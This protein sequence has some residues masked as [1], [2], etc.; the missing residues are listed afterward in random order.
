MRWRTSPPVYHPLGFIEPCL[1]TNGGTV[2]TGVQWAFEIKH[3]GF[4]LIC[5][6]DGDRVRVFSRNGRDWTDRVPLI[7]EAI[8]KLRVKSVTLDGEGVV[9]RPDGVTDF[10]RLRAAVGRLGSRDAFL[11][12]FDLLELDGEN[13]RLYEWHVRRTTL[14]S[15]IKRAGAGIRLSEHLDG[16]GAAAFQHACRMGLEG[17]VAKRRD[18]PYRSGR[19]PDW[20]KVKNPHAPAAS[21]T[22][23]W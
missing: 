5:R 11:Y 4:R 7:A 20:I 23:E 19:S 2:P 9:C 18:R 16:D 1:P 17:I 3:D 8:G 21:R 6:R 12:A 13:M 15:L 14:R 22:M 10:D